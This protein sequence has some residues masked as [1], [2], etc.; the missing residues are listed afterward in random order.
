[1][2]QFS[3]EPN[4]KI[5]VDKNKVLIVV[6]TPTLGSESL[7]GQ[8]IVRIFFLSENEAILIFSPQR[9]KQ[10]AFLGLL[11]FSAQLAP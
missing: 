6:E 11:K 9:R 1:M 4:T 7:Y 3:L 2:P 5:S 10:E 8:S